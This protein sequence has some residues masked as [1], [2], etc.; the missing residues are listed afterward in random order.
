MSRR[1]YWFGVALM[2]CC[3]AAPGRANAASAYIIEGTSLPA[4]LDAQVTAAG[5]TL[6]RVH[7]EIGLAMAMSDDPNFAPRLMAGGT[8]TS[9]TLDT[10]VQFAPPTPSDLASSAVLLP[11]SAAAG[12]T[13][14]AA[15]FFACQWAL[16]Q[17]DAPGAWAQGQLGSPNVKVAVLDSGVDPFHIDLNGKIDTANSTTVLT[18]G[19]SPCGAND[20]TTFFDFNFHGTFVSSMITGNSLGI[21]AVAPKS[22]VVAVKV[23]N[24]KGRGSFGDLIAGLHYAGKL[25]D[26]DVINMSL[27]ALVPR[28]GTEALVRAVGKALDFAR[29][30]G[31]L[32]VAASGNDGIDLSAH[33][34]LI[35]VPAQLHNAISIYA[36]SINETLASYS[37]HGTP[38][39]TWVGAPGGDLP[40]TH[41]P[42]AGCPVPANIQSLIIG[43]C[44]SFVCG[45]TNR[46]V[47]GAGTSFASPLVAG[48][49]ALIDSAHPNDN[50]SRTKHI[51]AQT[52]TD[53]EPSDTF[54]KGVV[55]ASRAVKTHD[56]NGDDGGDGG[57]N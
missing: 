27:G 14:T 40:N 15:F 45:A 5:G 12:P 51:L 33:P 41:A 42:L 17:I 3:V 29:D 30:R 18:P 55:N 16:K 46:Y 32:L 37:N 8:L 28:Q 25:P 56:D 20:E 2:V 7:P 9:V 10:L 43:A 54:A 19:S 11:Q 34:E 50:P 49:A 23:I 13:P 26:V 53:L 31:K 24:C 52:A 21:A 38:P 6:H 35:E 36:T 1:L 4:N 22:N 44:S 47:L 48:V 57:D 39:A